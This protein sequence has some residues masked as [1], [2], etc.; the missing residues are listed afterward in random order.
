M[1]QMLSR[2][3]RFAGEVAARIERL[4]VTA[5]QVRARIVIGTATFFDAFD[6]LAIAYILPVIVPH[7][8]WQYMF[9]VG[10]IPALLVLFL[11]RL[12]PESPRWLAARGRDSE[13]EAALRIV[14][15]GTEKALGRALPT[16]ESSVPAVLK[17]PSWSD[18]FGPIYLR[19]TLVVWV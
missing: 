10:A 16:P 19:R 3:D 14:E 7:L 1:D 2:N 18:V 9:F 13:A 17:Q 12:L 4:P 15:H 6:A 11:Q 5:W 8:G